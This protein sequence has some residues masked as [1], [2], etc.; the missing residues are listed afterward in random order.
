[1]RSLGPPR[2]PPL[3]ATTALVPDSDGTGSWRRPGGGGWAA[4]APG[5][6]GGWGRE[7]DGERAALANM[8]SEGEGIENRIASPAKYKG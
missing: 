5:S 6:T 7:R 4:R 3:A 1:M 8:P 2:R